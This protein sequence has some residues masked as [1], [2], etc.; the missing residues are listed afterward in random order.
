MGPERSLAT[1]ALPWLSGM[2]SHLAP[3][4]A[5]WLSVSS[6]DGNRKAL[7]EDEQNISALLRAMFVI[8]VCLPQRL[9]V[10]R[11][12]LPR[13]TRRAAV[14]AAAAATVESQR[15]ARNGL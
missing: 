6:S 3:G 15:P 7:N 5:G 14:A 10:A 12:D 11:V 9:V 8:F 13:L 1:E 2:R 4:H